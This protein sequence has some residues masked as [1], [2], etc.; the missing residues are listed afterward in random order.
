ML[1]LFR[2]AARNLLR[3]FRRSAITLA[4]IS[5]GLAFILWLSSILNGMNRMIVS[6]ITHSQVGHLQIVRSDYRKTK[7]LNQTFLFEPSQIE[8]KI[9]ADAIWA[10]RAYLPSIISTGENSSPIEIHGIDAVRER[11]TSRAAETV[12]KGEFL[13][14]TPDP[15]CDRK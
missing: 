12:K 9:G 11:K 6:S 13:D 3:N 15:G 7:L 2:M 5:I 8:E 1:L 10:P 14:A 4:S